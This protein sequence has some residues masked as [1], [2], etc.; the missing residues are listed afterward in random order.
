MV[1]VGIMLVRHLVK[2]TGTTFARWQEGIMSWKTPSERRDSTGM[3]ARTIRGRMT[4][5]DLDQE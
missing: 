1:V 2:S 5:L 4:A 3:G